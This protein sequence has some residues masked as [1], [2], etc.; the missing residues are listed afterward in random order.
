MQEERGPR[1]TTRLKKLFSNYA[2]IQK[3]KIIKL[4]NEKGTKFE[5]QNKFTNK[6]KYNTWGMKYNFVIE[7]QFFVYL[8]L[9]L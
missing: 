5:I 8:H 7:L 1:K 6:P 4:P 3:E 9:M 2:E